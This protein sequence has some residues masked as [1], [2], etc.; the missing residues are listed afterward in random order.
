MSF[1]GVSATVDNKPVAISYISPT[2]INVL[3]PLTSDTGSVPVQVTTSYGTSAIMLATMQPVAPAFLII[4]PPNGHVAARHADFS[5]LGPAAYSSPAY[6]F[7]PA[8]P[9]ET[10]LVYGVGFGQTSPPITNQQTG[11]GPL[12]TLPTVTIGGIPAVV[13]AGGAGLTAPGLYQLN[14][15]VPANAPNGDLAIIATYNGVTTQAS[16]VITVQQ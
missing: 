8:K 15:T 3:S 2:Q 16:A 13:L 6:T 7:T 4:D 5:L 9:G 12:P 1:G 11:V 14:V 10:V